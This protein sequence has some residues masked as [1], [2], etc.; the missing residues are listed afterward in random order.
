MPTS[1]R[2][3][4]L[5]TNRSFLSSSLQLAGLYSPSHLMLKL[6]ASI[7]RHSAHGIMA[8]A[9]TMLQLAHCMLTAYGLPAL[10]NACMGGPCAG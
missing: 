10:Y 1:I 7:G 5:V 2:C 3:D 8:G 4:L 9:V 6:H